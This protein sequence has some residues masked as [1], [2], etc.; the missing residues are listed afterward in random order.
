M[1]SARRVHFN[2]GLRYS[3]EL[4][5]ALKKPL[6]VFEALRCGYPW[7]SDR[8]HAFLLEGMP[9]NANELERRSV[10]YFP[11]VEPRAGAAKGLLSA[12]AENACAVVGDDF[13][14]FFLP[15]MLEAA[16]KSSGMSAPLFAVDSNGLLPM[17]ASPKVF[18][19]ARSFRS[20]LRKA[21]P[22]H[23]VHAIPAD[24]F[25][26]LAYPAPSP[27]LR[28]RIQKIQ[29]QWPPISMDRITKQLD[30][31]LSELPI[32]HGVPRLK[33]VPGGAQAGNTLLNTFLQ[34]KLDHYN[35]HRDDPDENG[36][37]GLSPYLHAGHLGAAEVF[38]RLAAEIGWT[39]DRFG[40][41]AGGGDDRLAFWGMGGAADAFADQLV[42]WRELGLNMCALRPDY[43]RYESLPAW[44]LATLEKHKAD[45]RPFVYTQA[46]LEG[47]ETH[48]SLWNAAQHQ[49]RSEGTIHNYLRMLWG[50]KI[51][52]WSASPEEALNTMIYLN[53]K[54][55]LD[56]RDPNSYSGIFWVL[57]R[58]DRAWGPERPIFGTVRYM[59][60]DSARKK[61]RLKNYLQRFG[62]H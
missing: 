18:T 7:A 3:L 51:L 43:D 10:L 15:R 1:T 9:G 34:K 33:R 41:E 5:A 37:S 29:Q 39:P 23:F 30:A 17:R 44:A 6:V 13:P 16:A 36:Q 11:Y 45:I 24:P 59:S 54:Y 27:A 38:S 40:A 4:A 31:I 35:E 62:K 56:G 22:E 48:D 52:E 50:K 60:S 58:Y 21:L 61:L 42:T 2:G 25:A 57:G 14:A 28:R 53:N 47:A 12:L 20:F 32:D 8:L 49:L 55:A 26:G 46:Q 19:V